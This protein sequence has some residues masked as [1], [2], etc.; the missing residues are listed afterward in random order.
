MC[1]YGE[2]LLGAGRGNRTHTLLPE[3]DFESGASTSSA[4]PASYINQLFTRE[5]SF[6]VDLRDAGP[7][8]SFRPTL[9]PRTARAA[10][11]GTPRHTST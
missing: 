1:N 10:A 5:T 7:P 6:L 9:R 3:P 11:S 4:I 2:R 8:R